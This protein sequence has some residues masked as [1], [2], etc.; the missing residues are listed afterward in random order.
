M[1]FLKEMKV[2][3]SLNVAAVSASGTGLD[4]IGKLV[5]MMN[6]FEAKVI[7]EAEESQKLY[8]EF[9]EWCEDRSKELRYE[10]KTAKSEIQ[11]LE[12]TIYKEANAQQVSSTK[13]EEFA[14]NIASGE[15]DLASAT[16]IRDREYADFQRTEKDLVDV[17]DTLARAITIIEKEMAKGG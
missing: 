10:V 16:K 13:I 5:Q 12:A 8:N 14:G 15:K 2:A 4:S 6:S 1:G 3:L 7:K 11:N 9:A 17:L